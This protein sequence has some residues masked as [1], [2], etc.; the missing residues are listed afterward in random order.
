MSSESASHRHHYG[1]KAVIVPRIKKRISKTTKGRR[2][3]SPPH[4]RPPPSVSPRN[5]EKEGGR[6]KIRGRHFTAPD[7]RNMK[8]CRGWDIPG[9]SGPPRSPTRFMV[10]RLRG[11]QQRLFDLRRSVN[12]RASGELLPHREETCRSV[13]FIPGLNTSARSCVVIREHELE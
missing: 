2:N 12:F 11:R 9:V 7:W 5:N 1:R 3:R 10:P 8:R 4:Y 13:G 6:N